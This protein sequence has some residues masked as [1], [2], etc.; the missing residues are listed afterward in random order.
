MHHTLLN[1]LFHTLDT[2]R[3]KGG[4]LYVRTSTSAKSD[5]GIWSHTDIEETGQAIPTKHPGQ[6]D[7]LYV[8]TPE[9]NAG[10]KGIGVGLTIAQYIIRAHHGGIHIQRAE[11]VGTICRI[12]LPPLAA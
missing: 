12:N 1:L 5:G 11:G 10:R 7:R 2:H 3:H 9:K 4:A 8:E 6:I